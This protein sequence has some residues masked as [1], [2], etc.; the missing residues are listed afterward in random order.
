MHFGCLPVSINSG[1]IKLI[2]KRGD[3]NNLNNWKPITCLISVYK[4]FALVFARRISPHLDS[5]ILKEQK[6]FVKG[7]FIMD[8]IITM[9]EGMEYISEEQLDMLF[10]KIDFDK[11]Y[12]RVEWDFILQSL[13]DMGFEKSF[14]HFVHCLWVMPGLLW[15]LMGKF[16]LQ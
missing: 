3:E 9:W 11:A 2:H 7:R 8:A 5:L 10:L 4:I 15:H 1:I 16:L 12:D 14:I 13:F 6:G